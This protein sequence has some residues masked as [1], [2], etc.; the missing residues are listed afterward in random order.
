MY[1]IKGLSNLLHLIHEVLQ[2]FISCCET[3]HSTIFFVLCVIILHI[4]WGIEG[5]LSRLFFVS[6]SE[7]RNLHSDI[8]F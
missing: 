4:L 8:W 6:V 1:I 5:L 3:E 2:A 7:K